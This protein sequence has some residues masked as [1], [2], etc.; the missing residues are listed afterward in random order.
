MQPAEVVLQRHDPGHELIDLRA[1]RLA[2]ELER[3]AQPLRGDPELVDGLDVGPAQDALV[4]A[5]RLV[6]KPDARPGRVAD[7]VWGHGAG[8]REDGRALGRD[9]DPVLLD[10]ARIGVRIQLPHQELTGDLAILRPRPDQRCECRRLGIGKAGLMRLRG[11]DEDVQI[12]H[13][14]QPR[15]EVAEPPTH[16]AR[17]IEPESIAKDA[18]GRA[19]PARGDAHA[20]EVLD[21]ETGP[22]PFLAGEHPREVEPEHFA[23][24]LGEEVVARDTRGLAHRERGDGDGGVG[25]PLGR[26]TDRGRDGRVGGWRTLGDRCRGMVRLRHGA[27]PGNRGCRAGCR[28]RARPRARRPSAAG[29]R[30][31]ST[32]ELR[33]R[34]GL[35]RVIS[36]EERRDLGEAALVAT[37]ELD[38]QL[39]EPVD[40]PTAGDDLDVVDTQLD[41]QRVTRERARAPELADR[42][43]LDERHVAGM[44][45]HEGA[46]GGGGPR[47]RIE[48][49]VGWTLELLPPVERGCRL[50]GRLDGQDRHPRAAPEADG[51]PGPCQ[52]AVRGVQVAVLDLDL[53]RSAHDAQAAEGPE[54]AQPRGRLRVAHAVLELHLDTLPCDRH[55]GLPLRH[56]RRAD[57]ASRPRPPAG[58]A[59]GRPRR[60]ARR[61]P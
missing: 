10:E 31:Q 4:P 8:R 61:A 22:R 6:G 46:S 45:E 44:L 32:V 12:A 34:H 58:A 37:L 28:C 9:E 41:F 29:E 11:L 53:A 51:I 24:G 42:D 27:R 54:C 55:L 1:Q 2:E 3:I 20:M 17:P 36:P 35:E 56:V 39:E 16:S 5:D 50:V 15:G 30:S 23:A 21:P 18:P 38:L 26:R 14:P 49:Q 43:R 52:G 40:H 48:G 60:R 7:T 13:R 19:H 59:H 33:R 25:R 57:R 47:M